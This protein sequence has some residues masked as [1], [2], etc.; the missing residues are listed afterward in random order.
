MTEKQRERS[1][2]KWEMVQFLQ[3]EGADRYV[4]LPET[5]RLSRESLREMLEKFGDVYVKPDR[6]FGGEGVSRLR[7]CQK[8]AEWTLQGEKERRFDTE[9]EMMESLLNHYGEEE[10]IVQ[11][12][13]PLDRY[14]EKPFDIRVHMQ[15]ETDSSWVYAGE[16]V[17]IGGE[18]GI[19]SNVEISGG[20]VLPLESVFTDEKIRSVLRTHMKEMGMALCRIMEKRLRFLEA[21]LDIGI[22]N[23]REFWLLEVNTDDDH[24]G[25]SHDLFRSLPDQQ[26]YDEI[27]ARYARTAGMPDWLRE[28]LFIN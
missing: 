9:K 11:E 4:R 24:G 15:K 1:L 3:N 2:G 16:V 5:R 19:V 23:G 21:G 7:I 14:E 26:L 27:R 28:W 10:C 12:T 25:P 6:G 20:S 13:A 22:K 18:E 17:R 8:G